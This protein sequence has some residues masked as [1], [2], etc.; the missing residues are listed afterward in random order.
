MERRPGA[1]R[2]EKSR[3][4]I[5]SA[6]S[7]QFAEK[8]YDH[9]TIEGIAAEAGVGKQTIYRWWGTKTA[10]VAECLVEGMLIPVPLRPQGSGDL[11]ADVEAW[12]RSIVDFIPGNESLM[13][14][15]IIAAAEDPDVATT[16]NER[17][18]ILPTNDDD[19]ALPMELVEAVLGAII[20][21]SLRRGTFDEGFA[22]RLVAVLLPD[23]VA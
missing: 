16:M 1:V 23:T 14:S 8:G 9:L 17:L 2:S 10:L 13:R 11:R 7:R 22:E 3:L 19:G 20:V 5:L 4:A 15:L 12:V 6:A 18:G 21:R